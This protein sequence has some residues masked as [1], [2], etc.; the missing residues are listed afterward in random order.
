LFE[1]TCIIGLWRLRFTLIAAPALFFE[2][3]VEH[4]AKAVVLLPLFLLSRISGTP[5][6]IRLRHYR[7]DL[8]FG[9][10]IGYAWEIVEV[11]L[12]CL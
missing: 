1:L 2:V 12:C 7:N 10:L 6:L 3:C 5:P 4:E 11:D 8:A 9:R